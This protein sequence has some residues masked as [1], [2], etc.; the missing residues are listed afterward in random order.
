MLSERYR[1][2][3]SLRELRRMRRRR[4]KLTLGTALVTGA[5][6]VVLLGSALVHMQGVNVYVRE[7]NE[8]I[9]TLGQKSPAQIK[10]E[11]REHAQQLNDDNPIVREAAMSALRAATGKNL[12]HDPR[13]WAVWWRVNESDW[14]YQPSTNGPSG[15]GRATP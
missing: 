11:L 5:V 7:V 9:G 1:S 14:E 6:L 13:A 10:Q 2:T 15:R 4:W 3:E 12:G 8:F